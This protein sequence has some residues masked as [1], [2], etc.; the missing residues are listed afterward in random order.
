MNI[1]TTRDKL[2]EDFGTVL[3]EAETLLDKAGKETGERA[4]DLRAQVEAKLQSAKSRLKDLESQ[5]SDRAREAARVTDDYV[6]DHPWQSVGAAA[7]I[8][9]LVGLMMNRR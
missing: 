9:F 6:H 4:R 5:A 3:S 8:G 1:E 2:V 7:A